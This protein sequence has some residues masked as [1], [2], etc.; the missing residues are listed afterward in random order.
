MAAFWIMMFL[1]P[2]GL[3]ALAA[4]V[5]LVARRGGRE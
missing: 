1:T 5:S 3:I 2:L 4:I